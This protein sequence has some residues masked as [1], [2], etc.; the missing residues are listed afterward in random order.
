MRELS[1]CANFRCAATPPWM[2][3]FAARP[4]SNNS[5]GDRHLEQKLTHRCEGNEWNC[6]WPW[7]VSSTTKP[8]SKFY[9]L[10]EAASWRLLT[11]PSTGS[12]TARTT[13]DSCSK[14]RAGAT[15]CSSPHLKNADE[16]EAEPAKATQ[17]EASPEQVQEAAEDHQ[18][19]RTCTRARRRTVLALYY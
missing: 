1:N 13:S 2:G 11:L 17:E 16:A 9:G 7:R 8:A 15:A 3:F 14:R 10:R 19:W 6:R 12:S 5:Q 4:I 18:Y